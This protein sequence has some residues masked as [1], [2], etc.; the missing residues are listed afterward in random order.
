MNNY[1]FLNKDRPD[2]DIN[3]IEE[4]KEL[5]DEIARCSEYLRDIEN[6]ANISF[7]ENIDNYE[8]TL[9]NYINKEDYVKIDT[10]TG[11]IRFVVM[12]NPNVYLDTPYKNDEEKNIRVRYLRALKHTIL[13][14]Y[15]EAYYDLN[16]GNKK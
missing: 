16:K 12:E 4:L 13:T 15:S 1:E 5:D 8:E 10:T 3:N 6:A 2:Y 14:A 7:K 9:N 11:R